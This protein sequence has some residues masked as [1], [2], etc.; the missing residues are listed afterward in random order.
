MQ[1]E[2]NVEGTGMGEGD[3]KKDVSDQ[4]TSEDQLEGLKN[5]SDDAPVEKEKKKLSAEEQDTGVEMQ[6]DFDGDMHDMGIVIILLYVV[7]ELTV[8]MYCV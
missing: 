3:G 8:Y 5:E 2:D 1:F 6:Q 4:I 7:C